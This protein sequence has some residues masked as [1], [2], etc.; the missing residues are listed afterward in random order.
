MTVMSLI[1]S[2]VTETGSLAREEVLSLIGEEARLVGLTAEQAMAK[3]A[4][5]VP[6]RGYI[7]EDISLLASLLSE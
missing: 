1:R 6:V 5:G 7:W 3:L 4:S 2:E